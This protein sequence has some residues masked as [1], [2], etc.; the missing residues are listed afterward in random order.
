MDSSTEYKFP[1]S[2]R[3]VILNLL[4]TANSLKNENKNSSIVTYEE[5]IKLMMDEAVKK[6]HTINSLMKVIYRLRAEIKHNFHSAKAN[7]DAS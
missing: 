2:N 6:D 1:M 7:A 5:A 3:D 4:K